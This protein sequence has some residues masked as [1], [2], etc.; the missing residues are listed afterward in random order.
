MS[1][2]KTPFRPLV[3]VNRN[4]SNRSPPRDTPTDDRRRREAPKLPADQLEARL[5]AA[6]ESQP[7]IEY[8]DDVANLKRLLSFLAKALI[9]TSKEEPDVKGRLQEML[10]GLL[11]GKLPPEKADMYELR[12]SKSSNGDGGNCL[13][14]L[15]KYIQDEIILA[16]RLINSGHLY[17]P[18][19]GKE[20]GDGDVEADDATRRTANGQKKMKANSATAGLICGYCH[21]EGHIKRDCPEKNAIL[22]MTCLTFGHTRNH[23]QNRRKNVTLAD[24]ERR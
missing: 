4:R 19:G 15:R 8:S 1:Q 23:C 12:V 3:Y 5:R 14:N 6:A 17:G 20:G 13:L 22:C 7:V 2:S 9:I 11:L 21:K 16:T 24:I 18:L 10:A